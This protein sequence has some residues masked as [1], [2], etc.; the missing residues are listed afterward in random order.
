M[1]EPHPHALWR[2]F[3]HMAPLD[4]PIWRRFLG[5]PPVVFDALYYDVALGGLAG[6]EVDQQDPLLP[7]WANLLKKRVDVVGHVSDERWIMEVKPVA[8]L[9]AFGQ[10]ICYEWLY[11]RFLGGECKTRKVVVCRRADVDLAGV[12]EEFGVSVYACEA[13]AVFPS[14]ASVPRLDS[15]LQT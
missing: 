1:L 9:E 6:A 12:Y 5:S 15:P 2:K 3:P 11:R 10:V 7:M 13:V 4:V 14:P 8:N